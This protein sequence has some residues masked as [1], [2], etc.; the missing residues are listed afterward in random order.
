MKNQLLA[1]IA[2]IIV[3]TALAIN[4][5]NA[6]LQASVTLHASGSVQQPS[7]VTYS[8]IIIVSG[9][10]YQMT[11][12]TTGQIEYQDTNAAEV[13]NDAI[14]NLTNGQS[15]LFIAGTYN[16]Q[17]SVTCDY[18]D[19]ITLVFANGAILFEADSM[20]APAISL[21]WLYQLAN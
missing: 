16:L 11:D 17:K 4:E 6:S 5:G 1:A 20:N 12:G 13:I 10:N 15:I 2:V 8:Y 21:Y 18:K 3:L 9:L 14:G 19:N 7:K